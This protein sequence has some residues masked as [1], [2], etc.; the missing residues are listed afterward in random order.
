M[1]FSKVL[2]LK[3]NSNSETNKTK[4]T[5]FQDNYIFK[6]SYF[7]C[8]MKNSKSIFQSIA[9][10]LFA[11]VLGEWYVLSHDA[12]MPVWLVRNYLKSGFFLRCGTVI[13]L[14]LLLYSNEKSLVERYNQRDKETMQFTFEQKQ[15]I[16][17]VYLFVGFL[18]LFFMGYLLFLSYL[19]L[20]VYTVLGALAYCFTLFA[21]NEKVS[22]IK[23]DD[24][25]IFSEYSIN[26]KGKNGHD[27]REKW[28]NIVNPFR[29]ILG[30]AANGAGKT[31]SLVEP[32]IEQYAFKGYSGILFDF[33][34]PTLTNIAHL[35][36]ARKKV[37]SFQ[38]GAY[39]MVDNPTELYVIN[40]T[41]IE[42]SHRLNP[43]NPKFIVNQI[44]AKEFAEA[45]FKAIQKGKNDND[46]F[47][48]PSAI[49]LLT[50]IIWFLKKHY[51]QYCS[52]PHVVNLIVGH[53]HEV[54]ITKLTEDEECAGLIRSIKTALEAQAGNQLAGVIAS[55]QMPFG[56]MNIPEYMYVLSG[57]DTTLDI[58]EKDN[59]K[60][61]CVGTSPDVAPALAPIVSLMFTVAYKTMNN[62]NKHHGFGLMDEAAQ[63]FIP[64]I[65]DIPATCRSNKVSFNVV[66]QDTAQFESIYTREDAS[67]LFSNLNYQIYLKISNIT[68]AKRVSETIGKAEAVKRSESTGSTTGQKSG[69]SNEG[70]NYSENYQELILP[71]QIT[72]FKVGE[73]AGI[74]EETK[75]PAF[76]IHVQREVFKT[77]DGTNGTYNKK[78]HFITA[79]RKV[80]AFNTTIDVNA[81]A[82][83]IKAECRLM[84]MQ[85]IPKA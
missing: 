20:L 52:F 49:S 6:T 65:H 26:I 8:T 59:P 5:I 27:G 31:V 58:N 22:K 40:F 17:F 61:I 79:D 35:H 56:T 78:G 54:L 42:R 68:S 29:G 1:Q 11:L 63:L 74:C 72:Q 3:R 32:C 23:T 28:L 83:R 15:F 24:K 21:E 16:V 76:H 33:K 18:S 53:S 50:A 84:L 77:P 45:I 13:A 64:N 46:K 14:P 51:P 57:D 48:T 67:S 73:M 25:I 36:F 43:L 55:L 60:V 81:V 7:I 41:D 85:E 30:I 19:P 9:F 12:E 69:S 44:Y 34:F 70:Y 75:Q 4:Q 66:A 37:L 71:N 82:T 47:F 38:E 80:P 62:Q 10:I 2:G 39:Q